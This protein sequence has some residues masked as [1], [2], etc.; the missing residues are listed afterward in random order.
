MR[1]GKGLV[2]VQVDDVKA[3]VPRPGYPEDGVEV[4]AVVIEQAALVMHGCRQLRDVLLEEPEGVGVGQHDPGHVTVEV[5]AQDRRAD[6][7][8]LVR[9]DADGGVTGEAYRGRVGPV[10]RVRDQHLGRRPA[11]SAGARRA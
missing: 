7:A 6:E 4:G 9:G 2:Q 11:L 10:R 5:L 1:H 3:H 8:P